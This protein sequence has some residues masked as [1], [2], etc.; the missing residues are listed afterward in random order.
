MSARFRRG[1]FLGDLVHSPIKEED[2]KKARYLS[3]RV[4]EL[5]APKLRK[6]QDGTY[7]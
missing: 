7:D 6:Y 5:A 2:E 1:H 3:R 4:I